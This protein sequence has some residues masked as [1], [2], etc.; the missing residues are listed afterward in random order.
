MDWL[1]Y[2]FQV[3]WLAVL[4]AFIASMAIGFVWYLP[5][6]LGK[7]WMEAVRQDGRGPEELGGRRRRSGCP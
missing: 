5:A 3:N 1:S 2:I 6:V 4:L 7:R